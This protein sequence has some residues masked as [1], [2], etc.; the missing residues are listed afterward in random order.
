MKNLMDN[1]QKYIV[2]VGIIASIGG[3]FY[4]VATNV[5]TINNRLDNLEAVEI[6]SVDVSPLETKIAILEEKVSKL[7]KANDNNRNPLLGN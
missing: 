6:T 1:L 4:S 3:G 2:L 5:T 7:E